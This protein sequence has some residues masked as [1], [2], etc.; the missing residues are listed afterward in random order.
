MPKKDKCT[1]MLGVYAKKNNDTSNGI[2]TL[3]LPLQG[4]ITETECSFKCNAV[5]WW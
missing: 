3:H 4:Q 2:N 5:G 1:N